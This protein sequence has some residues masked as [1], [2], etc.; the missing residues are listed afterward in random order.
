MKP[1]H[2]RF[3]F[4]GCLLVLIAMAVGVPAWHTSVIAA[5]KIAA[6]AVDAEA[7]TI[8]STPPS[9]LN[10]SGGGAPKATFD[11]A[12]DF[13]WQEF[14]ALTW[15]AGPQSGAN[16][17]RDTPSST[18]KY[19]D[20]SCTGPLVWETYRSKVETFPG[21]L[22][23]GSKGPAYGPPPG[24][25]TDASVSYGYDALPVYTYSSAVNACDA[26][27]QSDAT[28]WV[29]L[30]ETDQI[31]LDNM[32]AGT[33]EESSSPGNSSPKL[34][35]FTAKSNRSQYVYV[36]GNSSPTDPANQWWGH[37][38]ATVVADTK[39]Y[40]AAHQSSPPPNSSTLVS[41]PNGTIEVKAGWR[42]LNPA[43]ASSGRFHTQTVRFYEVG[44]DGF[45]KCYRDA[46]WGL[47]ALHIIQKTASAPYF[48]YATFEQADNLLTSGGTPVEDAEGRITLNPPPT[49]ATTPQVC[50]NDPQP[51]VTPPP[52]GGEVTSQLGSVIETSN[53][54]TCAPVTTKTYCT[55]PGQELYLRNSV[56]APPS[57]GEPSG[58]DICI[59]KRENPIPDYAITANAEAHAAIAGY[60]KTAGIKS[61]PWMFYKLVNVQYY[62]YD[63]VIVNQTPNGSLYT[64]KPPYTAENPPASSYYQANI[65]VETNRSLQLF[66]GGLSPNITTEWNQD[67]SPHKNT[68]YGNHFSNMGGCMGCH[69]SQGQNPANQAGDFSVILA[70]GSVSS[71]ESPALET[72]QGMIQ[73]PRNRSLTR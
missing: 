13:A 66:S 48:I 53:P 39:T 14:I 58:G 40:L 16:G 71:P 49:T 50:L 41:L 22:S 24:Y 69:G 72:T 64:P 1:I 59:D 21:N 67:G 3:V 62:P 68:Y 38:P 31:L 61:S 46:T 44:S 37:I 28:P 52:M 17:Q 27:Q 32:Y 30:D 65:V 23:F 20:P 33:V 6:K 26:S 63:K 54:A 35:R 45:S 7:I 25:V 12:A 8:S 70:R 29:N 43:E 47:V 9:E 42:P 4:G 34:I 55:S 11:Q 36:T 18:C 19:G 10:P 60:L 56:A 15:A 73:V 2:V 51:P 5:K 57:N